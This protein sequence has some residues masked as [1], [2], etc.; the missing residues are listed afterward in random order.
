MP[1]ALPTG[2]FHLLAPA[3]ESGV[4]MQAM[5]SFCAV[6][7]AIGG[8]DADPQAGTDITDAATTISAAARESL[9][10]MAVPRSGCTGIMLV[11]APR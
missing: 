11:S 5:A 9:E 2:E 4:R 8:A 7:R 1:S 3:R 10:K 6:A